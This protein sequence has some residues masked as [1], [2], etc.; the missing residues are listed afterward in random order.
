MNQIR[1]GKRENYGFTLIE[2]MIVVV[3]VGILGT[4]AIASYRGYTE[5]A[6]RTDA[7]G[8][9]MLLRDKQEAFFSNNN[10]YTTDQQ[11]IG[12]AASTN[13]PSAEGHYTLVVA[14]GNTANIATSFALTATPTVGGAQSNDTDC[15]TITLDSTG[16]QGPA[17]T[18]CWN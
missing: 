3:I 2:L 9:L 10:T 16:L 8:S 18:D 4:M 5:K 15:P 13:V 1:S 6:R 17:A 7:H 14:A 11:D 12:V